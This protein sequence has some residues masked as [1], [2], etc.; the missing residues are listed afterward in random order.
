VARHDPFRLTQRAGHKP[1]RCF[2]PRLVLLLLALALVA[3][4]RLHAHNPGESFLKLLIEPAGIT[5]ELDLSL[6]DLEAT[7]GLDVDGNGSVTYEELLARQPAIAAYTLPKIRLRCDGVEGSLRATNHLVATDQDGAYAV[8]VFV[9]D[10]LVP[11]GELEVEY[12]VF[13]EAAPGHRGLMKLVQG[14]NEQVALFTSA[15][16]VQRFPLTTTS[17]GA[18]AVHFLTDGIWHI[19]TGFDHLLFLLALLLP[20]VLR[21][22]GGGWEAVTDFR[23]AFWQVVRIVTAFTVAHSVTLSLATL[24]WVTLPERPVEVIIA[25]SVAVAAL[26]NLHP[27]LHERGWLVAFGFGL[28]HGFGFASVLSGLQ[29]QSGNLAVALVGF[30]VGVEVGQLAVV[31]VFLP[32]AF[33]ARQS[34]F[35]QRG[36]LRFGSIAIALVALMWV[37]QRG[38]G[39]ALLPF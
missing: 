15:T 36:A 22:T 28:I 21:R 20:A 6:R 2:F 32:L 5:G 26:N 13:F 7:V 33:A 10:G 35:Y 1:A 29:L 16:A 39:L 23:T 24:R 9:V 8:V 30:N 3:P 12:R 25:A 18:A 31:A 27:V 14:T 38:F 19:W 37:V 11:R 34:R 17:G 4:G